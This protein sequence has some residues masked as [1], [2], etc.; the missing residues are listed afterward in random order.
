MRVLFRLKVGVARVGIIDPVV[1]A[2]LR[3]GIRALLSRA[4]AEAVL[5]DTIDPGRRA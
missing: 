5:R 1:H 4:L 2:P 3:G